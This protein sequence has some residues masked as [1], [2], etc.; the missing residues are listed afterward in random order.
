[1]KKQVVCKFVVHS[2]SEPRLTRKIKTGY[3]APALEGDKV[4][5]HG[6]M[7]SSWNNAE[8]FV[9]EINDVQ[10]GPVMSNMN[11]P[12]NE[13]SKFFSS[14]P[15]GQMQFFSVMNLIGLK[16]GQEVRITMEFEIPNAE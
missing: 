2:A 15:S 9:R 13:N 4:G 11:D 14:T 6:T 12:E 7:G 16:P 5:D 3:S 8:Y 10:L 1:M